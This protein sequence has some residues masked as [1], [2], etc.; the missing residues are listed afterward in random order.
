MRTRS[1]CSSAESAVKL[2]APPCSASAR[3]GSSLRALAAA[4][5]TLPRG[6]SVCNVDAP[7]STDSASSVRRRGGSDG[8]ESGCVTA[9]RPSRSMSV[10]SR[11]R[12]AAGIV[13]VAAGVTALS[14]AVSA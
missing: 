2:T 1:S 10:S 8:K 11:R 4:I 7:R 14:A 13:D 12:H 9:T 6:P 3:S 5:C